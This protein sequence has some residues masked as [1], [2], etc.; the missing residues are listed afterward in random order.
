MDSVQ[1][2]QCTNCEALKPAT[3]EFFHKHRLGKL[4]LNSE[5]KSCC[6][7]RTSARN[8]A[9][10][11]QAR[12]TRAAQLY[13]DAVD[14]KPVEKRCTQ[15]GI[16]KPAT[17]EYFH[18]QST[19]SGLRAE[20]K[21]C[22]CKKAKAYREENPETWKATLTNYRANN[23]EKARARGREYDAANRK[24]RR[25]KN[26]AYHKVNRARITERKRLAALAD[27][28]KATA[29][30]RAWRRAHPELDRLRV[31]HRRA[32][33]H[34]APGTH[35][36]ADITKQFQ[37]QKG[38]CWWCGVKLKEGGKDKFHPDHVIALA[39]GGSNGPENIVCACPTCNLRKN[40]KSP[41]EFAGRLF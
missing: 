5:C 3:L 13:Y 37:L 28:E 25:A 36:A 16:L 35:T 33:K 18:K 4:G 27:P 23:L 32:L 24:E 19:K 21:P 11:D 30:R 34:N 17:L 10:R 26:R 2:K 22:A 7:A 9:K 31:A 1:V 14:G 40:A 38:R 29:K 20:C 12:R 15:C 39:R 41:L 8:K 6:N